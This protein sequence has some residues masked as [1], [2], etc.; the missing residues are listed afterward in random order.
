MNHKRLHEE[1]NSNLIPGWNYH[2]DRSSATQLSAIYKLLDERLPEK[3]MKVI[4]PAIAPVEDTDETLA[5]AIPPMD[6]TGAILYVGKVNGGV[7]FTIHN[8]PA[9]ISAAD[10][11]ELAYAI[12]R[13]V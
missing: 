5:R 4:V 12:L 9:K 10:A 2:A 6:G 13:A 11:E 1:A 8:N 7:Q 3:P